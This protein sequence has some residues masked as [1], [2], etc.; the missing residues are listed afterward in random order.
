MDKTRV[1]VEPLY[2]DSW[3]EM[4]ARGYGSFMGDSQWSRDEW[5]KVDNRYLSYGI[6]ME[7]K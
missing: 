2:A 4:Y 1:A 6:A 3:D 7:T 5:S